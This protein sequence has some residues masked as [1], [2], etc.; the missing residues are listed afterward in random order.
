MYN[1][2]GFILCIDMN[3]RFVNVIVYGFGEFACYVSRASIFVYVDGRVVLFDFDL[4]IGVFLI[5]LGVIEGMYE[6]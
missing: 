4:C 1:G 2:G 6:L 3:G 5:D